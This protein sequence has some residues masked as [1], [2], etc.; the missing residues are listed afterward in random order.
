MRDLKIDLWIPYFN[1][2]G[3]QFFLTFS[4]K[5]LS[6]HVYETKKKKTMRELKIDFWIPIFIS[7]ADTFPSLSWIFKKIEYSYIFFI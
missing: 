2:S 1:S 6:W 5:L 3:S 7:P 4:Q